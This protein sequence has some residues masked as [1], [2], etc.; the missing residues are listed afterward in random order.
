MGPLLTATFVGGV[1]LGAV[2]PLDAGAAAALA[3]AA[4]ALAIGAA[5]RPRQ[6]CALVCVLLVG[7][8]HGT[9]ARARALS[10]PLLTWFDAAAPGDRIV[11]VAGTLA[12]DAAPAD[13]AV[14]LLIDVERVRHEGRWQ[15]ATGRVQAHVAG[16]QGPSHLDE[17][18]AGRP[19]VTPAL[20]RRPQVWRN[21]GGPTETWQQLRRSVD[22]NATI[23]SA[24]LVAV[25]R[26][27]VWHEAAASL[28]R[29]VRRTM[30]R[31]VA[32]RDAR[33]A[34]VAVAILIGDRASLDAAMVQRLQAAGTYHVIAISGGNVALLTALCMLAVRLVVRSARPSALVTMSAVLVYGWVVGGDPSVARAVC[35]AWLFLGASA[36]GLRP[37]A[38][39]L[40]TTAAAVLT[41][42][43]PLM[44]IDVGAWL[45]FGATVGIV[46]GATRLAAL[47]DRRAALGRILSGARGNAGRLV[48]RLLSATVAAE[49][50]LLPIAAAVFGRVSVAGLLLNFIAIPAMAVVQCAGIAVLLLEPLLPLAHASALAVVAAAGV[51]VES[52]RLVDLWPW[53]AWRV[54]PVPWWW[55]PL[56]YL[57]AAVAVWRSE[58]WIRAGAA[59]AAASALLVIAAAPDV[60]RGVGAPGQLRLVVFDVGQGDA[61]LV[62]LPSGPSLLVDAGGTPGVFDIGARIVTP[63]IWAQRISGLDWLAITHPDRDHIGG[64][65]SVATDLSP[66]E[67]WE[68]V[69]V[70]RDASRAALRE[71][72]RARG[73]TWREVRAGERLAVGDVLMDVLHPP[74]PDWERQRVRND[75]SIVLRIRYRDV[76][77]LLTGDAGEEFESAFV[78]PGDG[79]RVRVLKAAHHGSR[80]STSESFV[81]AYVPDV[82]LISAGRGNLFGH[83]AADVLDRLRM[84]G[85][86][87]FRTDRDGAVMVETDGQVVRVRAYGG[88]TWMTA[89]VRRP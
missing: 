46:I 41:L 79:A 31:F 2:M 57:A 84:A 85:A 44:T 22:L 87:V 47:V 56:Y 24:A 59:A 30:A 82:V 17:W 34:A 70:P 76:E 16:Q 45:S 80:S 72:A 18:T 61:V 65:V 62:Q 40:L 21:F 7:V 29:H 5:R 67:V 51:L 9:I 54:P 28:R 13:G 19:I 25:E 35:A 52:A 32:P 73:L 81:R 75:D 42:V 12:A 15:V 55:T 89:L 3:T 66:R 27:R 60:A 63:A 1:A 23:K 68:G 14:R 78:S 11:E 36:L 48:I 37:R 74:A 88:R 50:V 58:P 77:V 86:E 10:P 64:A 20:L 53:L 33:A 8:C 38:I 4:A 39:H 26:G 49:L 71:L 83:P 69:A 43:D 6:A